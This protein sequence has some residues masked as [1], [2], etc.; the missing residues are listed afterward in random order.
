MRQSPSIRIGLTVIGWSFV[1]A[2]A[3]AAP[4]MD[5]V[6]SRLIEAGGQQ[7]GVCAVVLNDDAGGLPVALANASGLLVHAR[8]A[9]VA[10]VHTL[11]NKASESSLGIDRIAVEQGTADRLPYAD[12]VVDLLIVPDWSTTTGPSAVEMLR[13]LRPRGMALAAGDELPALTR[14]ATTALGGAE[15]VAQA[16]GTR[17]C[18]PPAYEVLARHLLR[19]RGAGARDLPGAGRPRARVPSRSAP[20]VPDPRHGVLVSSPA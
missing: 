7:R 17:P 4:D 18:P 2:T 13:V 15:A 3:D 16:Q 1:L 14:V 6:A 5:V 11:R 12:N 20:I 8:C 10:A 19:S 9:D